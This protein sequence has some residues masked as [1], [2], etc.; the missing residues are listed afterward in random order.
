MTKYD[1]SITIQ[2][3]LNQNLLY[4][5]INLF[6]IVICI[7]YNLVIYQYNNCRVTPV[8]K[9]QTIS[10]FLNHQ[11]GFSLHGLVQIKQSGFITEL[12]SRRI[13]HHS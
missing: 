4:N 8:I 3:Y 2:L 10:L 7:Q 11:T 6:Q 5:I 12:G 13:F 9:M 1:I